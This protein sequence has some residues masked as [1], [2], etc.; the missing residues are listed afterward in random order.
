MLF[1][2]KVIISQALPKIL[3]TWT[4][5]VMRWGLLILPHGKTRNPKEEKKKDLG[6]TPG[7]LFINDFFFPFQTVEMKKA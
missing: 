3:K 1:L 7:D 5:R 2:E 6:N 4:C